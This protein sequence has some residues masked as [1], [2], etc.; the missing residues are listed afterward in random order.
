MMAIV[1]LILEWVVQYING[2]I[3]NM[4]FKWD[5]TSKRYVIDLDWEKMISFVKAVVL[6]SPEDM[7][8]DVLR[9]LP[10][11]L[12]GGEEGVKEARTHLNR[13]GVFMVG[14]LVATILMV[15]A[16]VGL[17]ILSC[18]CKC[19]CGGDKPRRKGKKMKKTHTARTQAPVAG[20]ATVREPGG[21]SAD[22]SGGQI[23]SEAS[24]AHGTTTKL[25]DNGYDGYAFYSDDDDDDASSSSDN[26]NIK[27]WVC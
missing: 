17:I 18:C 7:P 1:T 15:I 23:N 5:E 6:M 19:C 21:K 14:P 4:V 11:D 9:S 25:F 22:S 10:E 20:S 3:L 12:G 16:L 8:L 26:A 24:H 2:G 27:S 13:E